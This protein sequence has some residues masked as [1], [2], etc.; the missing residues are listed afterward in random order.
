MKHKA[1]LHFLEK[2][3]KQKTEWRE[4]TEEIETKYY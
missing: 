4:T 3:L 2:N 1:H